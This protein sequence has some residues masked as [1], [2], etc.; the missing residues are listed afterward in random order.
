MQL[1]ACLCRFDLSAANNLSN[2]TPHH[3]TLHTRYKVRFRPH[4]RAK[5][6]P[7]S[8]F[9]HLCRIAFECVVLNEFLDFGSNSRQNSC[10]F[11]HVINT[12]CVWLIQYIN[13][14]TFQKRG[15]A[16]C[17]RIHSFSNLSDSQFIENDRLDP[18][19]SFSTNG[20]SN[21]LEKECI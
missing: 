16:I 17:A 12:F 14:R 6:A 7:I 21:R 1:C 4:S 15:F 2:R 13:S 19:L 5:T 10:F 11:Y 8:S 9:S 3:S 18:I 20:E